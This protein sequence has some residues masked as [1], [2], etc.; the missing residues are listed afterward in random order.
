M[1]SANLTV[2]NA[3]QIRAVLLDLSATTDERRGIRE[4]ATAAREAAV[5]DIEREYQNECRRANEEADQ[6]LA[7]LATRFES[8]QSE[9]D[10]DCRAKREQI[11]AEERAAREAVDAKAS[12]LEEDAKRKW[13]EE[14]WLIESEYES[15]EPLPRREFEK[16]NERITAQRKALEQAEKSS[17]AFL[18]RV[19]L[20]RVAEADGAWE[21]PRADADPTASPDETLESSVAL[22]RE[23]S[24]SLQNLRLARFSAGAGPGLLSVLFVIAVVV[25]TLWIEQWR[26]APTVI[27]AGV[28]AAVACGL[29]IWWMQ[30]SARARSLT[31]FRETLAA[32]SNGRAAGERALAQAAEQ[33]NRREA[34]NINRRDR[35]LVDAKKKY[36]PRIA[37]ARSERKKESAALNEHYP[38][39]LRRLEAE[40]RQRLDELTAARTAAERDAK[41]T[42]EARLRDAE[43]MRDQRL[44]EAESAFVG[45][46]HESDARWSRQFD[47]AR[48]TLGDAA[49][50]ARE[51]FPD[52]SRFD[53]DWPPPSAIPP[54][55]PFGTIAIDLR[56]FNG[57]TTDEPI[58]APIETPALL[59]FPDSAS[60]LLETDGPGREH[61]IAL[62]QSVMLRLLTAM[63][64][65][66]VRFTIFDPVGLGQSFAGFMH[67]A[68]YSEQ[69]VGERIW[70]E[71]RHIEQRLTDLTEH[72]E[73]VIQKYLRNEFQ[74]IAEYNEQAGEIAEPY[75]F[76]VMADCPVNLSDNAARRLS[77]IVQTGA[78]CGVYALLMVDRRQ[79]APGGLQMEDLRRACVRLEWDENRVVWDDEAFRRWPLE[80]EAPPDDRVVTRYL[81]RVGEGAR[82]A[83]RVEVP[84]DIITPDEAQRWSRNSGD[85]LRIPL[86]RAG[87]TRLQSLVLGHGTSQHAL[88]AGKTGSGKST[89]L[90]VLV[91]NASLWY[92][93]DQLE[94]YLVDFK[95]G[96][97][98][99]TYATHELPHA[100][101]IAIESDREFGASVLRRVD[102]EIRAR[103]DRFRRVGAQD[104]AAFR[105]LSPDEP[106]PRILVIIDEFQEFFTEEDKIAQD[107]ALLLDRLV[108]QGRAFGVHVVL[109]SQTLGGAYGLARSTIGQMAIRIA[110]QCSEADAYLILNEDNSAA[111]LLS[112]PG[113]A[114]YNDGGGAVGANSPFQIAWLPDGSHERSLQIVRA[115]ADETGYLPAE[116]PAVFE[117]HAPADLRRHRALSQWLTTPPAS[118][119]AVIEAALG[120]PIAIKPPVSFQIRRQGGANALIVGQRDEAALGMMAAA[121]ITI[122]AQT[123]VANEVDARSRIM[124]FDGGSIDAAH[125][126]LLP[127]IAKGVPHEATSPEFSAATEALSE[128][129]SE[130]DRRESGAAS[131]A[132]PW[133]I[134]I[135][136]L[137]RFRAWRRP[138]DEFSFSLDENTAPR[139]DRDLARLVREGPALGIHSL[140]WVD[141]VATAERFF[142]RATMREFDTRILF[143]MSAADSSQLIDSADASRLGLRRALYFSEEAGLMERLRPYAAPNP[144]WLDGV[145]NTLRSRD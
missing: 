20:A 47:R 114:I 94:F 84:F 39:E 37:H 101:A 21:T 11:K 57:D 24:E 122:A 6:S 95:K 74:T 17:R 46:V 144:E 49:V 61:A 14:N 12:Q 107:A 140:I 77:S 130:I 13:Q 8:E 133:F 30:R 40:C 92:G 128:I 80:P 18:E 65:G 136:G 64:P 1:A 10:A 99:K 106:M 7:A 31:V 5:E 93:P 34:E 119:P 72:M 43:M 109:G 88:V 36:A 50:M 55:I 16:A 78:R 45:A 23:R 86:G 91:T 44:N 115:L 87:A 105:R 117:G 103:G 102:S 3:A 66:K 33:K 58:R 51:V 127:R 60:L 67:L 120:E 145:L 143:Q 59:S 22:A 25:G 75:R 116:P 71:P 90:H 76:L 29:W 132:P 125:A 100:R 131:P 121:L 83:G 35:E 52:L 32:V 26:F 41:A 137:Q 96:V 54:A 104:L 135:Y 98:F 142:D 89:L 63:P 48:V 112:R 82:E 56:E 141:T 69:L 138:A 118:A 70:T 126:G 9:L 2:L 62:M 42:L 4:S 85:D 111:R 28:T 123:P 129:A 139:P 108:R 97:E 134:L 113:E 15:A 81:Q 73:S 19:R 38:S 124:V 79:S 53:A 68:D 110:L 27:V